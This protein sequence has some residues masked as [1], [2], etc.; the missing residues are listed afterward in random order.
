[1][2]ASGLGQQRLVR[3]IAG[4]VVL[5]RQDLELVGIER[6]FE[7]VVALDDDR[8]TNEGGLQAVHLDAG[9]GLAVAVVPLVRR[10]GGGVD[11]GLGAVDRDGEHGFLLR[12]SLAI[13]H[14]VI[15]RVVEL[16]EHSLSCQMAKN[17]IDQRIGRLGYP[18]LPWF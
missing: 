9:L 18:T 8:I 1:M 15:L 5:R 3:R 4:F 12:T 10:D 17:E 6:S 2:T 7:A 16:K 13:V 14:R 11:R